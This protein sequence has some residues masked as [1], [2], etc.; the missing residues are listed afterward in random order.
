M[1]GISSFCLHEYPLPY[2]LETLSLHSDF[3]E[4]MDDGPHFIDSTEILDTFSL[5][6][7]FHA[8]C[9]TVNI[10]SILEPIR[11]AS[12]E[13]IARCFA[14]AAEKSAPVVIHPGYFAWKEERERAERQFEKSFA[15]LNRTAADL[16]V[17]YYIENMGNWDYFFLRF[18]EEMDMIDGVGLALDVGHANLNSC[19]PAFLSRPFRHVHLHD[20]DGREDSHSPAGEG[21]IDF[22]AVMQAVE[23]ERATPVVEVATLEGVQKT[24]EILKGISG[25]AG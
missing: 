21:S 9:R 10:A 25:R 5:R 13:V 3:V 20:N 4:I 2:A 19:L 17:T 7:A 8:P 11:K 1:F 6:Y 22:A 15:E 16:S 12:V 23:R 14:L 18:P 24:I